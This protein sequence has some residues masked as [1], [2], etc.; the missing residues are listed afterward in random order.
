LEFWELQKKSNIKENV[1]TKDENGGKRGGHFTHTH[2]FIF[3]I[4]D[5][6]VKSKNFIHIY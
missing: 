4:K 5:I 1:V 3:R 6:A 2:I